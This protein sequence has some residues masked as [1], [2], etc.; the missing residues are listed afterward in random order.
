MSKVV[1][2]NNVNI[3]DVDTKNNQV[4]VNDPTLSDIIT[5]DNTIV[6]VVEIL[7]PGPQGPPGDPSILTGSFVNINDFNNFT[8]SYSTGSFT[9]SFSGSLSGSL[10]GTASY[11]IT[12]S[13][14]EN[15]PPPL[16]ILKDE[17]EFT[18]SQTFTLTSNYSQVYFI[19]VQGQGDLSSTQYQL[20]PPNQVEILDELE[21]GDY[22]TILYSP[23]QGGVTD[24]Y[25][26]A[27]SDAILTQTQTTLQQYTDNAVKIKFIDVTGS[28]L[29]QDTDY[30]AT[31]KVKANLTLTIPSVGLREDFIT[32]IDVWDGFTLT[33]TTATGVNITGNEGTTQA[34]NTVSLLY[35]D[36]STNN[37]RLR[38][39]I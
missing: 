8:S 7:T 3:V 23:T 33:W 36:G 9:G 1:V 4:L 34:E 25:T 12:A 30:N 27:E 37:Y 18:N 13:H 17:F 31:L 21:P 35:R 2:Q 26:K 28:R 15:L 6:E 39:E 32:H 11:A 38:G 22:I 5:I 24:Y 20:Q 16:S 19:N 14:V 29:I 10:F